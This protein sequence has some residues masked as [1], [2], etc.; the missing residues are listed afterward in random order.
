MRVTMAVLTWLRRQTEHLGRDAQNSRRQVWQ[1]VVKQK[2][3]LHTI[4]RGP[5]RNL[6]VNTIRHSP[7][8]DAGQ[9]M[10]VF[11]A[12]PMTRVTLLQP[13]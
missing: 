3:K 13:L 1:L 2:N 10:Y 8:S 11:H 9:L 4:P 7:N 5:S 6:V 12:L